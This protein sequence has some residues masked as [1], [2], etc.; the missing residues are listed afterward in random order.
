MTAQLSKYLIVHFDKGLEVAN[1]MSAQ[2][3]SE[4]MAYHGYWQQ[5]LFEL[6]PNFGNVSDLQAL[7]TAVHSR[8]MYLM[9]DVVVNHFGWAGNETTINYTILSPFD[10]ESYFHTY[11]PITSQDYAFDQEAVEDVSSPQRFPMHGL[12]TSF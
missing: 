12:I 5:N 6:N 8:G 2:N 7:S 9:L 10:D 4:G 3:T 11:C 1:D